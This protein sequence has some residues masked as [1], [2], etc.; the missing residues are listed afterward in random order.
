MKLTF[1]ILTILRLTNGFVM[2]PTPRIHQHPPRST[3]VNSL[4]VMDVKHT[5]DSFHEHANSIAHAIYP[6][7]PFILAYGL[8]MTALSVR[9]MFGGGNLL[10]EPLGTLEQDTSV[11]LDDVAGID[12]VKTEVE[13]II[14]FLRDP[15]KYNDIGAKMPKGVL[16]SSPPGCGK[17]MLAK[18]ISSSAGVPFFSCTG[19]SFVS[20]YVGNGPKRVRELFAM[21]KK[22][23]PCI[24]FID[25]IDAVGGQRGSGPNNNEEREATLN[26][27]L[28]E[29][30]GFGSDQGVVVIGATNM[31]SK[32][33]DALTRPGRMDRKITISL[34][35]K[36]GRLA[37]LKSHAKGKKMSPSINLD[38]FSK[39]TIGFSGADLGGLLNEAAIH[40]VRYNKTQVET[41]HIEEAFDKMTIGIRLEDAFVSDKSDEI[42]CIHEIGHGLVGAFQD[43]YHTVS[44]ISAIPSSSGA[45]GFTLFMPQEDSILPSYS[46]LLSELRVLLGGRAAESFFLGEYHVTTG[47]YSD[48]QRAKHIAHN[49]VTEYGMGGLIYMPDASV[50]DQ[51]AYILNETYADALKIIEDNCVV[52][53]DLATELQKKRE[54]NGEEFY[55]IV[56]EY[57]ITC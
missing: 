42:V 18:A 10:G 16:L 50:N 56:S 30:D 41:N 40:A 39:Q 11:S 29:L 3:H 13:E 22:N 2:T 55:K 35:D 49:M 36:A 23:S 43:D 26:E 54:L 34:P 7:A 9:D 52:V 46:M 57:G 14:S 44:R 27:I 8:T 24:L 53:K 17:T 5:I 6:Y 31:A 45:G 47:A 51:I 12:Y 38:A 1:V 19:S 37:I 32:L 20:I 15:K 4:G 48:I 25:E 33:D 28:T 21:A